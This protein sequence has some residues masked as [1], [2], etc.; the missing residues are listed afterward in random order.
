M[1]EFIDKSHSAENEYF[2]IMD[3]F[4]GRNA[5]YIIPK[6]MKLIAQDPEYFS[7]YNML[8][9]MYNS[10]GKLNE[11]NKLIMEAGEKALKRILDR[12]GAWPSRLEWAFLENR[13]IIQAL[14]N[15]S[16]HFWEEGNKEKSLELLRNLLKSNPDDNIGARY[17]ILAIRNN[18][19]L[20]QFEQRFN[21]GGF[22][23]NALDEWFQTEHLKYPDEFEWWDK[24]FQE[25]EAN[26]EEEDLD[27]DGN[28]INFDISKLP[29]SF[30]I[31]NKLNQDLEHSLPSHSGQPH[32]TNI[33]QLKITLK[34]SH[35]P[36]WRR[37]LIEDDSTFEALH[38][39]IQKFFGWDYDHLHDFTASIDFIRNLKIIGLTPDKDEPELPLEGGILENRTKLYDFLSIDRRKLLYT[40]DFGE[41]WEHSVYLEEIKPVDKA[42]TYPICIKKRGELPSEDIDEEFSDFED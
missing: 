12:K 39:A 18:M 1:K 36:V 23:D 16:I 22:Y 38:D 37:I 42:L 2:K 32:T 15:L 8:V 26:A 20:P 11:S 28:A 21:K 17:F 7:P 40:Y 31:Y 25:I 33:F 14:L 19:T 29:A 41:N 34:G 3:R 30:D 13:H 5:P 35:P 6:L 9:D 27:T 10:L 4:T 24:Q